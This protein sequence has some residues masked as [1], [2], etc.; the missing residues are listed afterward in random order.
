MS[1]AEQILRGALEIGAGRHIYPALLAELAELGARLGRRDLTATFGARAVN[2]GERSGATKPLAQAIRARGLVALADARYD[3]A[4]RDLSDALARFAAL[5]TIWEEARTRYVTAE[6]LRREAGD[7]A[8]VTEQL[9][10]A[11]RLFEQVGAVRDIA[12]AKN[13]LAGGEIRLP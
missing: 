2:V 13:A 11:L 4:R 7:A 9:T 5:G 1:E 10:Q 3:D 6:L 12:R 8:H